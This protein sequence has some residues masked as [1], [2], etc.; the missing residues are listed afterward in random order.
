MTKRQK[1]VFVF[2]ENYQQIFVP[3]TGVH[4]RGG[5]SG[6]M[7]AACGPTCT[8]TVICPPPYSTD[9]LIPLSCFSRHQSLPPR[10]SCPVASTKSRT[11]FSPT[12]AAELENS[13]SWLLVCIFCPSLTL[14]TSDTPSQV[15]IDEVQA[16]P[17]LP[18]L[19]ARKTLPMNPS[20]WYP[21]I[22]VSGIGWSGPPAHP[23]SCSTLVKD[24]GRH[25]AARPSRQ[26]LTIIETFR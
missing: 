15:G 20:A 25:G 6:H 21:T 12:K 18:P 11:L 8:H 24:S 14:S 10:R 17:P 16:V 4:P 7:S 2:F 22:R 26:C 9:C 3:T 19:A 13:R 1:K 5:N 23:A